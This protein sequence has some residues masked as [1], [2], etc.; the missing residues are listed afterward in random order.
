VLE[1]IISGTW[2]V[3]I[4]YHKPSIII[5]AYILSLLSSATFAYF[6]LRKKK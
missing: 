3:I 2:V 5:F 1:K 4:S 6:V